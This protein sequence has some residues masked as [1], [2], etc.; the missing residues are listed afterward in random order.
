MKESLNGSESK[1]SRNKEESLLKIESFL[2]FFIQGVQ[3][4]PQS[5]KPLVISMGAPRSKTQHTRVKWEFPS[6]RNDN[7]KKWGKSTER[8]TLST[9]LCCDDASPCRPRV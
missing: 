5:G 4:I 3:D 2:R 9:V 8:L 6:R 7:M 1:I